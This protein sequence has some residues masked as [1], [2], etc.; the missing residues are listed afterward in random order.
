MRHKSIL[1][2]LPNSDERNQCPTNDVNG[3]LLLEKGFNLILGQSGLIPSIYVE[4]SNDEGNYSHQRSIQHGVSISPGMVDRRVWDCLLK[5][6]AD[7][8]TVLW[9]PS[10]CE[11][12][13]VSLSHS[14]SFHRLQMA[15]IDNDEIVAFQITNIDNDE[16]LLSPSFML[17]L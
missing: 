16:N 10:S 17:I 14:P 7:S 8:S 15:K 11:V 6:L 1:C 13:C 5:I 9:P 2:H 12:N 3:A 4:E